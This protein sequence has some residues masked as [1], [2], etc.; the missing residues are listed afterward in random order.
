MEGG[1]KIGFGVAVGIFFGFVFLCCGLPFG[2]YS[3]GMIVGKDK[4]SQRSHKV[5]APLLT[6]SATNETSPSF[7]KIDP[8]LKQLQASTVVSSAQSIDNEFFVS[9]VLTN[10][11]GKVFSSIS[12]TFEVVDAFGNHVG[13]AT[14]EAVGIF[15]DTQEWQ[16]RAVYRGGRTTKMYRYIPTPLF[17]YR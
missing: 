6:E 16:F 9:G 11:T 13:Y 15:R 8:Y 14:D 2:L 10:Q 1:F 3:L 12:I 4:D 7:P 5:I 17:E